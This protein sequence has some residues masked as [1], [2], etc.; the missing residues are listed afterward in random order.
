MITSMSKKIIILVLSLCIIVPTNT[1]SAAEKKLTVPKMKTRED[2]LG[3][4]HVQ[5]SKYSNTTFYR[6]ET[7]QDKNMNIVN[8]LHIYAEK[9]GKIK[10]VKTIK[11]DDFTKK[12]KKILE[13]GSRGKACLDYSC[14]TMFYPVLNKQLYPQL[15]SI[16]LKTGKVK[17]IHLGKK[18]NKFL[19]TP[20]LLTSKEKKEGK[21]GIVI[22]DIKCYGISSQFIGIS[23]SMVTLENLEKKGIGTGI[24]STESFKTCLFN[25]SKNKII[26]MMNSDYNVDAMTEKYVC[27]L[28]RTPQGKLCIQKWNG[29]VKKVAIN[30]PVEKGEENLGEDYYRYV[31]KIYIENNHVFFSTR[32]GVYCYKIKAKKLSTILNRQQ[33]THLKKYKY[34]TAI[35]KDK[36]GRLEILVST[37]WRSGYKLLKL[38]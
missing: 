5:K 7:K 3:I 6:W 27:G 17:Q 14:E 4:T 21:D 11:P 32:A 10:R 2:E 36:Q 15:Y 24:Q 31:H 9:A 35:S 22:N 18:L 30:N 29:T 16:S 23:I 26:K 28:E 34:V 13:M 33:S 20:K 25:V 38:T 37:G 19:N 1:S 12:A 8:A